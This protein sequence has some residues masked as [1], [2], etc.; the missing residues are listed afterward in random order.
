M[1]PGFP[2]GREMTV[3]SFLKARNEITNAATGSPLTSQESEIPVQSS[4]NAGASCQTRKPIHALR[5]RITVATIIRVIPRRS[6]KLAHSAKMTSAALPRLRD[7][8]ESGD[9]VRRVNEL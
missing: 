2:K 7:G 9:K 4:D 6:T 1:P 8:I 5:P 3:A